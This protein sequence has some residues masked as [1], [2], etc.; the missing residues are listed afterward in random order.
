LGKNS[1]GESDKFMCS[2]KTVHAFDQLPG[3]PNY[4]KKSLLK[5]LASVSNQ[6]TEYEL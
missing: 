3:G 5:H 6:E 4:E 2:L 1:S